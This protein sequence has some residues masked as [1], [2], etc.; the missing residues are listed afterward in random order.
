MAIEAQLSG[1]PARRARFRVPGGAPVRVL[2]L[3]V[4]LV[5]AACAIMGD[6]IAP[7]DPLLQDPVNATAPP[8]EAHLLGTDVLGRDVLSLLIAGTKWAVLGPIVVSLGCGLIG[9]VLG[10][11]GAYHGGV[12][13]G[14]VNRLAD[15]IYAL[16]SLIVAIVVVGVM[17][18]G[19]WMVAGLL[20]FL[21]VPYQ[22]RII[23]SV[24]LAQ[25]NLPYVE[26]AR[27]SGI[28]DGRTLLFH[29][30]PNIVPTVV[31]TLLL[32]F[33]TAMIGYTALA[34]L[35]IGVPAGTPNWGAMIGTGQTYLYLNPWL[36]VAPAIAVIL[37]ATSVTILGDHLHERRGRKAATR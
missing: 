28:S 35:G 11:L 25:V 15:L 10:M 6:V 13:D 31:A 23:R 12:I 32:D 21:S 17:D 16:P 24:T 34:F 33:V 7:H 29:V 3:L 1:V 5:V 27:T 18:G 37:T 2:A 30:L 4:V 14:A 8:S 26:A 36:A 22:I 9:I 19:Y 20:T